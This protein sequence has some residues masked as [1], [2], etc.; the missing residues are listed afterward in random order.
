MEEILKKLKRKPDSNKGD[1]GH[2][3]I[4]GSD[5]GM[6]GA[7]IMAAEAA[8]RVG[9]GKVSVLTKEENHKALLSRLPNVMTISQDLVDIKNWQKIFEDKSVIVI[10]PGLGQSAW[11][12]ELLNAALESSLPKVIDADALNIIAKSDENLVLENSI[13]TPHPGEASRLL[14]ITNEEVQKNREKSAKNLQEKFNTIAILKGQNSLVCGDDFLHKCEFGNP[15]MATAGMGD[16]LSGIIGG[17]IAQ[18]LDLKEAAIFGVDLHA[19]AGDLVAKK[20]GEIGIIPQDLFEYIL[21]II[22][23]KI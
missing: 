23:Q 12:K 19:L 2:V 22:N 16:V 15:G 17:L 11:S 4:I 1:F 21:L 7:V 5:M 3:L 18:G 13:I 8:F 10:G 14:N 6:A 20:Q 9:S